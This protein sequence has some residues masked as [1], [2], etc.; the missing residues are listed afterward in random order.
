MTFSGYKNKPASPLF[1]LVTGSIVLRA[2]VYLLLPASDLFGKYSNSGPLFFSALTEHLGDYLSFSTNIPPATYLMDAS[3]LA[4]TGIKTAMA[5]R[6]FLI[7]VFIMDIAALT[8]L[9]NATQKLGVAS[10]F[11]FLIISVFSVAL[12]P[13]ELW[14]DGMH[15]DHLTLFFTT[16]FA[17][18]LV[19]LIKEDRSFNNRIMV[20]VAGALL[21]SQ[22]AVNSLVVPASLILIL[23]FLYLPKKQIGQL[24]LALVITLVLPAVL[25]VMISRKN[26]HSGQES[27][28]SNKGGPAMMMVVQRAYNYDESRV[29][30]L[31]QETGVPGWYL[32]A[33]DHATEPI[34]PLTQKPYPLWLNLSQAFGIC[35]FGN[36]VHADNPWAFDF[37]PLLVYLRQNGP[38]ELLAPVQADSADAVTR[39]YRFAGYSPE[40]SPR[41]IG[42]YGDVSKK[43]FFRSIIKN[44]SGM[45]RAFIAQQAIFALYGPLFPYNTLNKKPS[46]LARNGLRTLRDPVPLQ[47]LFILAT[48]LFAAIAA[49]TYV[50]ALLNIPST[51][52][53]KFISKRTV[54]DTE[55]FLLLSIPVILLAIVFSCLV[56]GENDRY[57]MQ[58]TP[59]IVIL[60]ACLP[61]WFTGLKY[62]QRHE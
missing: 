30:S 1:F 5:T 52:W 4:V 12:I 51:A 17:W 14:R 59:Y 3:V 6:A 19:R 57:F 41:W 32:W 35:F 7:L 36:P 11:S 43:I 49:V 47:P 54:Q 31:M 2:V 24:L 28:T 21:V 45:F 62:T 42:I 26:Q 16:L 25:L 22:S 38:A 10:R 29:R 58:V 60:A 9:Y 13:F 33:H 18:T 15:Y 50:I 55:P 39:P 34:D 53:K 23:A 40:L 48:L 27:L 61:M 8:L 46:L 20:S 44:P 56:G 37:H